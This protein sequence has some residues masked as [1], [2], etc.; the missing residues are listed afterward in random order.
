MDRDW[1]CIG[2]LSFVLATHLLGFEAFGQDPGFLSTDVQF[3]NDTVTLAGTFIAPR[4]NARHPVVVFLHGSGPVTR[5]GARPYAEEFTKLGLASLI[6]DK[7]GSGSSGGSWLTASLDDLASDALAAVEFVKR[8]ENVDSQRVGFWG[9]SQAAW[10]ATLAAC[11][12]QDIAFM[13]LISGGGASP[14]ESELFSYRKA[15]ERARLSGSDTADAM[16]VIGLYFHYLATGENRPQLVA[17]LDSARQKPWYQYATLDRI[18]PSETNRT[19]WSWVATWDPAVCTQKI[20]CPLLLMFG[21]KD[22][23]HPTDLAVAGWRDGLS[24]GGNKNSTV[25]IFPGAGHGIRMREG[26]TGQGRAPFADG[27]PELMI[28]WLWQHVLHREE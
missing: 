19:N 11:R 17:E 20:S 6:F 18:L 4:G 15:F 2:V 1:L 12:S 14:H 26:F 10:V 24:K 7:R 28:G 27:Y 9:V 16:R 22:T 21:D 8:L 13:V 23:D 25:V 3:H 5:E